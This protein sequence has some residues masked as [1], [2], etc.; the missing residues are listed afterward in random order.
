VY[1]GSSTPTAA[2]VVIVVVVVVVVVVET[3][4]LTRGEA[5]DDGGTPD[6]SGVFSGS[7]GAGCSS[8]SGRQST[9]FLHF[10]VQ[11]PR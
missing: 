6:I 1:V 2:D 4:S 11:I 3:D 10:V 9:C 5:C 7:V 8:P